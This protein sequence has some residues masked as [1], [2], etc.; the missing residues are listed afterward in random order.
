MGLFD[1]ARNKVIKSTFQSDFDAIR[2]ASLETQKN[3]GSRIFEDVQLIG[4]LTPSNL[5][6]TLPKLREKYKILRNMSIS[7]GATNALDADY[8]YS[9]LMESIVL[10]VGQTDVFNKIMQDILG[11][12]SYIEVIKKE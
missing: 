3:V 8:A 12:L 10:S 9:A 6:S 2:T 1:F 4:Q 7:N 5:N 11:W